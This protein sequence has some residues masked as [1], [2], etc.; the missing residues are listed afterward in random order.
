MY[1]S[2]WI[3]GIDYFCIMYNISTRMQLNTI[4]SV[5]HVQKA[6]PLETDKRLFVHLILN[7]KQQTNRLFKMFTS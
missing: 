3:Q 6:F 4:D 7:K 1:D 2:V 5:E